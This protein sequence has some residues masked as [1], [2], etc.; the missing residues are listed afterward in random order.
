MRQIPLK[1]QENTD[2][3]LSY[4]EIVFFCISISIYICISI[5]KNTKRKHITL[6]IGA[7]HKIISMQY[8]ILRK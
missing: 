2:K 7:V 5:E 8:K 4:L 1:A 3:I 6:E